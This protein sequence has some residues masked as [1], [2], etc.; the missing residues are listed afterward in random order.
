MMSFSIDPT[1]DHVAEVNPGEVPFPMIAKARSNASRV[2]QLLL[3]N[4]YY[5]GA[6]QAQ[7]ALLIDR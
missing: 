3:E 7:R 2:R 1:H 6:F 4:L 5:E